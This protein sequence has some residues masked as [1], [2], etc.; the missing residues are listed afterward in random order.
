ML[1]AHE[2]V[3]RRA[4]ETPSAIAVTSGGRGLT[5]G[6]LDRRASLL[7]HRLRSKVVG[8]DG[9][10]GLC[11]E[12]S[13]DLVVGALAILKAGGAYIPMDP[14]YPSKRL[15]FILGDAGASIVV[16]QQHLVERIMAEDVDVLLV[17]TDF[18]GQSDFP[19]PPITTPVGPS[20]LAYVIYTSGST[21][22]PKGVEITHGNL[23][24]LI[25]WH[26]HAFGVTAE[27]RAT[28]LAGPGFDAV[29]WEIWPYLAAG[30]S[31][32]V[33]DELTRIT[34][35][36]LRD[37]LIHEGITLSFV[38]TVLA[39]Q[40]IDL[41]WPGKV[42]L[43][44]LLTGGDT[45]HRFP[46][47]GLPFTLVNNYGPT[48]TTVV[49]TS[50]AV[51]ARSTMEGVPTIGTPIDG[52][53]AYIVDDQLQ[54]MGPGTVGEL[55]V[56]G[57][58]VA[59]GYRNRPEL[60][61]QKF[62]SN[63]W[64]PELSGRVYRTGD[65]VRLTPDGQLE[66][67]GR[68]DD[69]VK[70]RGQRVEL[71]E[72]VA[73]LNLHPHVRRAFVDI[74][75]SPRGDNRLAAYVVPTDAAA[76]DADALRTHL[77]ETLPMHMVP[78]DFFWLPSLP[79]NQNGKVDRTALAALH[80]TDR[81]LTADSVGPRREIEAVLA[82]IVAELL[83]LDSVGVEENFFT[84][85][86][87]S[88]LGAQV[89]ARI[90]DRFGVELPLRKI[91]DGPTVVEMAEEVERVLVADVEAMSEVEAESLLGSFERERA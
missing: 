76:R 78:T 8:P 87:H 3:E 9:V 13:E 29:V 63:I 46:A 19:L 49:A 67:V 62:L 86:G 66:F 57:G 83:E 42:K 53:V 82:T 73:A 71:G 77:A 31:V 16:T 21:G 43:R 90:G 11:V 37:W 17:D 48:E 69:Q 40:L 56:G 2:L 88:L 91:F 50:G 6:E 54:V 61:A 23:L 26:R 72:I 89:I 39:E 60:T 12:R 34:P 64:E 1:L 79:T 7:A 15:R 5:F 52:A 65:L 10:V 81:E 4:H 80:P 68:A 14:S 25:S 44:T 28:Q 59:R 45:L 41:E 30:A 84:L 70:V 75:P 35:E 55:L 27:D 38:P 18:E 20:S 33:A 47:V 85:G 32:H 36:R 74:R 51:P 24:H 22:E 58:G